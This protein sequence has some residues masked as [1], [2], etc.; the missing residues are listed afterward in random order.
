LWIQKK[1]EEFKTPFTERGVNKV[2]ENFQKI[3][4]IGAFSLCLLLF[5]CQQ[6]LKF[7]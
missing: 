7:P 4:N 1:K 3:E 6:Q 5:F 2:Q